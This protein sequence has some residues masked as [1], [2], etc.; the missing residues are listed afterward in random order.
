MAKATKKPP[1]KTQILGS[2]AD[3]TGLAKKD[4]AAV[5]EALEKQV[6]ESLSRRGPGVFTIPGLI[7]IEKKKVPAKPAR[8]GVMVLGQ[9]RDIPAK[10]ATTKVKVRALKNLKDMA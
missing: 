10:P 5:F 4:V 9:L 8:K 1:T 3:A 7:K 6:K 2:I